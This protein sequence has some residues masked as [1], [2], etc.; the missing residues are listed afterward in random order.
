MPIRENLRRRS[1]PYIEKSIFLGKEVVSLKQNK[2]K[3]AYFLS[4]TRYF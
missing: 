3:P 1:F 4:K 2:E